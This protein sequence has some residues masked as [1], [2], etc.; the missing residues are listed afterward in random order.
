VTIISSGVEI[1]IAGDVGEMIRAPISW[2]ILLF[3]SSCNYALFVCRYEKP[4]AAR[5]M[6]RKKPIRAKP[7][8]T[9]SFHGK[10]QTLQIQRKSPPRL[11]P[12]TITS[13][14]C[15]ES[16]HRNIQVE[17]PKHFRRLLKTK[18]ATCSKTR[19]PGLRGVDS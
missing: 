15:K 7:P 2:L 12:K 18:E 9:S 17:R 1:S 8:P 4:Y 19:N 11:V 13:R 16:I 5:A 14:T 3:F 6:K 10:N